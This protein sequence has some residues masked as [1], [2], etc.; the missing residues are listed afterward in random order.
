MLT[1]RVRVH[2]PHPLG[3]SSAIH[4]P[5]GVEY[6]EVSCNNSEGCGNNVV[7]IWEISTSRSIFAALAEKTPTDNVRYPFIKVSW[8]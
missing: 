1:K 5:T 6:E 8:L 7:L 3:S 4:T 2:L